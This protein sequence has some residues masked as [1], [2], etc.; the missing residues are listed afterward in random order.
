ML[1][2]L[3]LVYIFGPIGK[4]LA[5]KIYHTSHLKKIKIKILPLYLI[6]YIYL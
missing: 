1:V 6:T 4:S 5:C 3:V 2:V